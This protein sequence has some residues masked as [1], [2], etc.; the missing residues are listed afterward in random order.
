[1][2]TGVPLAAVTLPVTVIGGKLCPAASESLRVHV[3]VA[4]VHAP[5]PGPEMAVMVKP[6]GGSATVTV[7]LVAPLPVL[8]TV[9][10]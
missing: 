1:M 7:P 2:V 3:G 8:E 5:H 6:V 4:G 9:M 10:V